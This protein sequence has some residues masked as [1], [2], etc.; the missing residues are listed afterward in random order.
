[1][2][3]PFLWFWVRMEVEG[4]VNALDGSVVASEVTRV[5]TWVILMVVCRRSS[6]C[7]MGC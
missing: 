3:G 4:V 2:G 7:G 6:F 5:R 1:M